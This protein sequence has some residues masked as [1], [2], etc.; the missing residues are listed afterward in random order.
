MENGLFS[1]HINF[2]PYCAPQ[3]LFGNCHFCHKWER[4]QPGCRQHRAEYLKGTH[5]KRKHTKNGWKKPRKE[6]IQTRRKLEKVEN[7]EERGKKIRK[8]I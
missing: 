3:N 8:R 5:K 4:S 7:E 6:G 2:A 1:V